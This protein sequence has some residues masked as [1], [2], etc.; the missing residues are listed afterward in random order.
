MSYFF[1]VLHGCSLDNIS[2]ERFMNEM[3]DSFVLVTDACASHYIF[4][5]ILVFLF[6]EKNTAWI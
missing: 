3:S 2:D 1:F 5:K 6:K 4:C